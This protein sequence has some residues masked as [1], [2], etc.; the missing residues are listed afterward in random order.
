MK[1]Q[2]QLDRLSNAYND[3]AGPNKS[4]RAET[5]RSSAGSSSDGDDA[6]EDVSNDEDD[7]DEGGKGNGDALAPSDCAMTKHGNRAGRF[8]LVFKN[9]SSSTRKRR[10]S[11]AGLESL[12]HRTKHARS[13]SRNAASYDESSNSDDEA[14]N[15]V[16]LVSDAEEESDVERLEEKNIIN[17][18]DENKHGPAGTV[19]DTNEAS[20]GWDG[21][22]LDEEFFIPVIPYFEDQ[23]E[24]TEPGIL[25]GEAGF[26][27]SGSES[28]RYEPLTSSEWPTHRQVRFKDSMPPQSDSLDM[29][30]ND[31]DLNGLFNTN[32][33][34]AQT[35]NDNTFDY[36]NEDTASAAGN[37]SGYESG[38]FD[39][40]SIY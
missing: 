8:K 26:F 17:S 38:L 16:D 29:V 13:P 12:D 34:A 10:A 9:G 33:V 24:S 40:M 7:E 15:G 36:D 6:D 5:G 2:K 25:D 1:N 30:N 21:S 37:S 27:G 32:E 31:G 11:S 3:S 22:D 35:V 18:E 19:G 20:D 28:Y 23:F 39:L 4:A 14:Y